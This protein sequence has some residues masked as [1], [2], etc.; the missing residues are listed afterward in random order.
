MPVLFGYE[1]TQIGDFYE[2]EEYTEKYYVIMSRQ[3]KE[4]ENRKE[5]TLPADIERSLDYSYTT[6]VTEDYYSQEHGG[7][8]IY[9]S[10]YHIKKLYF[11]NG[12]YLVFDEPIDST[13]CVEQEAEVLDYHDDIYYITLTKN[14]VK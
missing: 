12:G 3:P 6:N 8:D 14:K 7:E 4:Q 2:A 11:P 10:G 1:T 5:Y 9:A 13:L